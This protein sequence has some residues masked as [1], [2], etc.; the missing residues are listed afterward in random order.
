ME[1]NKSRKKESIKYSKI[2]AVNREKIDNKNMRIHVD[3]K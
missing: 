2:I 3:M 1:E